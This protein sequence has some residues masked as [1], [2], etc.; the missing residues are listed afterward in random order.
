LWLLVAL[1]LLDILAVFQRFYL[2]RL[3]LVSS[4]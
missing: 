2:E 1:I 4:K 3:A